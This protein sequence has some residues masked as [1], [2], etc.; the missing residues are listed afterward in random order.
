[1]LFLTVNSLTALETGEEIPGFSVVSGKGRI[2]I[3]EDLRNKTTL[4]FYEDRSQ[5]DMNQELKDYLTGLSLDSDENLAVIVIDCS[6]V[7]LLKK[8]WEERLRDHARRTGLNVYGD[9]NGKMKRSFFYDDDNSAFSVI[10]P[11]GVVVY[12]AQGKI[13]ASDFDRISG[14]LE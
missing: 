12:T 13:P 4:L 5:M 9:W 10:N 3:R 14:F 7:G 2:L 1:L 8:L 6:D 11:R